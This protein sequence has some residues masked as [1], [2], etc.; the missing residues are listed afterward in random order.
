MKILNETLFLINKQE[1][2]SFQIVYK[3]STVLYPKQS[4]IKLTLIYFSLKT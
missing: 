2:K 1:E 3:F 4:R